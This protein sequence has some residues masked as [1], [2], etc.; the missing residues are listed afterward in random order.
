[1]SDFLKWPHAL[2]S[3]FGGRRGVVDEALA[4]LGLERKISLWIPYFA[5]AAAITATS[6]MIL[7]LPTRAA[8][9]L[10]QTQALCSFPPPFPIPPFDYRLLWHDRSDVDLGHRWIRD[11]IAEVVS[12][13]V[14]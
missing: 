12:H 11:S 6:E 5:T 2:V 3:I 14:G 7:T 10:M 13:R 9:A 8:E 4:K 1:M